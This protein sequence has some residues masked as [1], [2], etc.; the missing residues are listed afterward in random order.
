M[1]RENPDAEKIASTINFAAWWWNDR[2][3]RHFD[4]ITGC[5]VTPEQMKSFRGSIVACLI[6]DYKTGY[7]GV[8]MLSDH[9]C[10]RLS[11]A[12]K[13]AGIPE[14]FFPDHV[15]MRVN[16]KEGSVGVIDGYGAQYKTL[17]EFEKSGV[18][19]RDQ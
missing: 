17:Y 1:I 5:Y 4:H 18:Y 8:W 13:H 12:A 9:L 10:M 11:V 16:F 6:S 14:S 3:T 2:L 19:D 7:K 15:S